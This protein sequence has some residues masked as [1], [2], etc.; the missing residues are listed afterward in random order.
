MRVYAWRAKWA[1]DAWDRRTYQGFIDLIE[2]ILGDEPQ[3]FGS[4]VDRLFWDY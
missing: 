1:R 4:R 3:G 2:Y